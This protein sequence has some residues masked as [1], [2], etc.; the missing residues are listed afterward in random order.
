MVK[1]RDHCQSTPGTWKQPGGE[2]V[3]TR[4]HCWP[5][6]LGTCAV[7]NAG[8]RLGLKR[9]P[10]VARKRRGLT[11]RRAAPCAQWTPCGCEGVRSGTRGRTPPAVS[12]EYWRERC[13]GHVRV[14]SSAVCQ[15]KRGVQV[16]L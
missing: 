7:H 5:L 1:T 13:R 11:L 9:M 8:T 16:S 2:V 3:K 12:P 4:D 10:K 6:T 15:R 14:L